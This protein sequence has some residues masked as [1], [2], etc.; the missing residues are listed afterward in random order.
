MN[1]P[2]VFLVDDDKSLSEALAQALLLDGYQVRVFE[3]AKAALERIRRDDYAVVVTDYLMP[4]MDGFELLEQVLEID[5]AYSVIMM[6]GHGDVPMAVR[7]MQAGAYDFLQKPCRPQELSKVVAQALQRR[8]LT[9]EN[10]ALRAELVASDDLEGRLVGSHPSMVTLRE[11]LRVASEAS[12]DT[13]IVGQTGTGKEV[14]AR[15]VHDLGPRKVAPFV[16]INCAAIP[17]EMIESELFGHEAGAFTGAINQRV[18]R[19]EHAQGGTVFLD[20][21]ESMPMD[22]QAKLL[23]VIENRTLERLGS[24]KPVQLD[25]TFVGAIS[26]R[27]GELNSQMREDLFYRLN[28]VELEL[29]PLAQRRSD[30]PALFYHLAREARG[31][32]RKEIPLLDPVLEADL[33]AYDWPGNVR[34]LRNV[35]ERFVLGLWKGFDNS[36]GEVAGSLSDQLSEYERRIIK[37]TLAEH[38]G[39]MKPTYEALGLSR[40]GLYDKIQRL[41]INVSE[42]ALES[43]EMGS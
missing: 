6:T 38:G 36:D 29:L 23:R 15:A 28:V 8:R 39:K 9:L 40:K 16:A 43:D 17:A 34:E 10:R 22:L 20:E 21:L 18:G 13:L 11:R 14:V 7:A 4:N 12:V 41:G 33:M 31:K 3:Q 2:E 5:S 24:N 19:I 27:P 42:S 1:A 37:R 25:V 26:N 32:F 35:A 30:I